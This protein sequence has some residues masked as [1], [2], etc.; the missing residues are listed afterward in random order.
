LSG[1]QA[2]DAVAHQATAETIR[3]FEETG[4]PVISDG[5]QCKFGGF[6][7]YCLHGADN[8]APDG[9]EVRF[10]DGHSRQLPRLTSGRSSDPLTASS[11]ALSMRSIPA[12]SRPR[13]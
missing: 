11:S 10:S 4:S 12:W 3:A 7:F 9:I 13:K 6:D 1:T 2:L 8:I 5:E